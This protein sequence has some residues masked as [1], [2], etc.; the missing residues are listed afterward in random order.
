VNLSTDFPAARVATGA[1]TR[2]RHKV[3]V[4]TILLSSITYLDRVCISITASDMRRD[5]HLDVLQMSYVFSAFTLAYGMF[6]IPTGWWGDRIGTR[7]VLAR[8][9]AWW[10]AFTALTGAAFSY[11]QL[12]LTRFL[13]GVGEAGAWPN[14]NITFGRWFP[15]KDRGTA[16]GLFFM[17][18][19]AAAGLTPILIS[20]M[21]LYFHWRTL[22]VL[23]GGIGMV[24]TVFW[25][26][27]FRDTPREHPECNDAERAYIESGV[28]GGGE[29]HGFARTPWAKVFANRSIL[30]LAGMY[31]TQTYGF[32]L[33]ITW[34]PT[35]LENTRGFKSVELGLLAGLP[36]TLSAVAD[37]LGG[38]TTDKV[39]KRLG[40]GPG[41]RIVGFTSL[42]LAG[43]FMISGTFVANP[44]AAVVLL[45][46]GAAFSNFLLAA[47]W[48]SCID[49]G[50]HH[51]GVVGATM[52]TSG[53]I[54]GFLSPIVVGLIVTMYGNW[55]APLYITGGLYLLGALCWLGVDPSRTLP[56]WKDA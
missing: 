40:A 29:R 10:S 53:Q 27:W 3:L 45:G 48:G 6:E 7:R 25:Y 50:G 20:T 2:V 32:Y 23:L 17:G 21:L 49:I 47:A 16:Q 12:L 31:F 34:M 51:S 52:N 8:I 18:A 26:R 41:R 24:W 33:F 44:Y 28:H 13:F 37:L 54:G 4:M 39:T 19:H 1:P 42:A 22:F 56:D 35:Y 46:I 9:V 5:L 38:I 55:N 15:L 43:L 11:W 14:V 36:M 30:C